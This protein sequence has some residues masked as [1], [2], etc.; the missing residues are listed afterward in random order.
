MRFHFVEGLLAK[1][2]RIQNAHA[3]ARVKQLPDQHR[4][5]VTRAS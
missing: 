3:A 2:E 4:A 5:Q 1:H